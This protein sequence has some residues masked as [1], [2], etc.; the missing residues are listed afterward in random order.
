[1]EKILKEKLKVNFDYVK[2]KE[3]ISITE[4]QDILFWQRLEH[5]IT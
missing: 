4:Y 2:N 3:K 1:M 5:I